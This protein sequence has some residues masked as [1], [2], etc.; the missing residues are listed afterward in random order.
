MSERLEDII[1]KEAKLETIK[2]AGIDHTFISSRTT[3]TRSSTYE[4]YKPGITLVGRIRSFRD[5]GK[6][7]FPTLKMALQKSKSYLNPTT[8][9]RTILNFSEKF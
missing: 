2:Q 4:N 8:L 7:I 6:L 9:A 5:M 3:P 1:I